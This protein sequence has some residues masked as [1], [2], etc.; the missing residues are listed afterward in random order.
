M[1]SRSN[2]IFAISHTP[3]LGGSQSQR[4]ASYL[5][6]KGQGLSVPTVQVAQLLPHTPL[7]NLA[8]VASGWLFRAR[9]GRYL[10]VK[11]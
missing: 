11:K 2:G 5:A 4:L 8:R 7:A 10:S 6:C 3:L 1:S 9:R